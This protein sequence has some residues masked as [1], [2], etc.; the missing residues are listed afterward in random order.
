MK[1]FLIIL[2][3]TLFV[4]PVISAGLFDWWNSEDE[5]SPSNESSNES[6]TLSFHIG[7]TMILKFSE[8][9]IQFPSKEDV[10]FYR[11]HVRIPIEYDSAAINNDFYIYAQ[12]LGKASGNYSVLIK[13][14]EYFEKVEQVTK[15]I[16]TNFSIIDSI[17]DFSLSQGF[18]ITDKDFSIE[19]KNLADEETLVNINTILESSDAVTLEQGEK[20][21]IDFSVKGIL[22]PTFETIILSS[23]N[24]IYNI[25]IYI[26][27]GPEE[28]QEEKEKV[29]YFD[30]P[31][32]NISMPTNSSMMRI[33]YLKNEGD[34][35]EN[36]TLSVSNSLE[37][38]VFLSVEKIEYLEKNDS[39]KIIINI[40]SDNEEKIIHG[41]VKAKDSSGVYAYLGLSL[42][43]IQGYVPTEKENEEIPVVSENCFERLGKI[44][45][46]EEI[47][48]GT[49][50]RASDG[51]CCL[52]ECVKEDKDST[53][54]VIGWLLVGVVA[55]FL[56]LF[57]LRYKKT[58]RNVDLL[59]KKK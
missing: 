2:L 59:G 6:T 55:V 3:L 17:A 41:Q 44:C 56:L 13:D 20:K 43:F 25:P 47:C 5:Q 53:G 57:F 42:N 11:G 40:S 32:F 27:K 16:E 33:A 45:P 54:K 29:F 50:L 34:L 35:L 38:Y 9:F 18:I 19:I 49:I 24:Q 23:A 1:K 39:V 15:D 21:E 4:I 12:L 51:L 31:Y 48:N 26:F 28:Q 14:A 30:T 8:N 37:E 52:D 46:K 7:E 36:I 22:Y 58:K 10:Y